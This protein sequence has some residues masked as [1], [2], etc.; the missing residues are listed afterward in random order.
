MKVKVSLAE[1]KQ[2]STTPC[3]NCSYTLCLCAQESW[4]FSWTIT[5]KLLGKVSINVTAEAVQTSVLCGKA[6]VTVPQ[7]GRKDTIIK[8][9]LVL[10]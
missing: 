1:S 10:V 7:K 9:L 8:T 3:K 5:P 2:F 6:A 4:T